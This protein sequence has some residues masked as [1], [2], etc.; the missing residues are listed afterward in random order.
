MR[1]GEPVGV[2]VYGLQPD[3]LGRAMGLR[4]GDL[5]ETLNDEV[6][7]NVD[8]L[9]AQLN[10]AITTSLRARV[11]RRGVPHSWKILMT[12][13]PTHEAFRLDDLRRTV[14]AQ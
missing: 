3:G 6:V 14:R 7:G 13:G 10:G 9:Q 5:I 4:N 8:Q 1:A 11:A 2:K 12:P